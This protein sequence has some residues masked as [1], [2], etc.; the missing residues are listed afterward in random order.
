MNKRSYLLVTGGLA[1]ALLLNF[2]LVTPQRLALDTQ[3]NPRGWRNELRASLQGV[4]FWQ[5]QLAAVDKEIDAPRAM[6]ATR[7]RIASVMEPALQQSRYTIDS[8]YAANP[9]LPR[10][11]TSI[12]EQL[13]LTADSIESASMQQTIDS[14]LQDRAHS[15][16]QCRARVAAQAKVLF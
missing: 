13:R 8:M 1:A 12:P 16:L 6:A 5:V 10:P 14:L 9:T 3:C 7:A 15:L 11:T 2:S 4:K